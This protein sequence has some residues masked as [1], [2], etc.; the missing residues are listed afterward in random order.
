[1]KRVLEYALCRTRRGE[2]LV[3]LDSPLGN[4]QEISP[5]GLEALACALLK[6]AEEATQRDICGQHYRNRKCNLP[7]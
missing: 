6:I 4:G 2:P 1:M 3:T 7:Y 5:T